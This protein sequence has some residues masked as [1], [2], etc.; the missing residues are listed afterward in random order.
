[1]RRA[2]AFALTLMLADSTLALHGQADKPPAARPAD[3]LPLA[4][5]KADATLAVALAP[6]AVVVEKALWVATP[7]GVVVVEAGTNAAAAPVPLPG[8]AP[9]AAPARGNKAVWVPQCT[10]RTLARVD[11]MSREVTT[12]ALAVADPG[13]SIAACVG[14]V[15]V[16]TEATGVIAR[17]D[18]DTREVVAEVFV[19]RDPSGVTCA[20]ETLWVTSAAGGTLTRI[21]AHTNEVVETIAVGP[22]PGRVVVGEGGVWTLN[23]GDHSVTR[24]DPA[25]N[26]VVATIAVGHDVGK[27]DIAAGEGGLWLSAPGSP[28]VR[29]DPR[30]NRV[31][32]RFIG[33]GGGAVAVAHGSVWIAAT[34]TTTWR[35]DPKLAASLRP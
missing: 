18:P 29:I 9:C 2:V 19:A 28:L 13:G 14:S 31:A 33:D 23:R 20:G 22:R 12:A 11:E 16:A 7:S 24:V 30:A 21:N 15:W 25:T 32:Q 17:L 8:G 35:V 34:S 3:A 6:G 10:A 1:M 4:R 27:G 5:L 26:K